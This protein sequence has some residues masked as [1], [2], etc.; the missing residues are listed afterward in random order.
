MELRCSIQ[1]LLLTNVIC[2]INTYDLLI[3]KSDV[4]EQQWIN[5]HSRLFSWPAFI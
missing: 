3:D 1:E 4:R 5:K 2:V